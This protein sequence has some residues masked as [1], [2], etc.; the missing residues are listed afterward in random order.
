MVEATYLGGS[1]AAL[2]VSV[3]LLAAQRRRVTHAD[4]L[5]VTP[6]AA[7]GGLLFALAR[8]GEYPATLAPLFGPVTVYFTTGAVAALLWFPFRQASF[9]RGENGAPVALATTGAGAGTA[10]GLVLFSLSSAAGVE[11]VAWL[12]GGPFL[13]GA[14]AVLAYLGHDRVDPEAVGRTRMLGLAV[15]FAFA[16]SGIASA[17]VVVAGRSL[18][19]FLASAL[20]ALAAAVGVGTAPVLVAGKLLVGLVVV[21]VLGRAVK[22]HEESGYVL[23]AAAAALALGPAVHA[24]L[25]AT[26]M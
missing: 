24:L 15:P 9:A 5:A 20:A 16:L 19:G 12:V 11:S 21:S 6:W 22:N 4:A 25:R 3:G 14:L 13:A 18:R 7:T 1:A 26:V 2:A 17:A 8:V 23:L 10:L